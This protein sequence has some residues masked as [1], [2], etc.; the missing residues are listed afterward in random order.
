MK[1]NQELIKL[2]SKHVAQTY[3]RYPIGLV[4]GKG[5]AVWDASGKK[6]IDIDNITLLKKLYV[7]IFDFNTNENNDYVLNFQ[8]IYKTLLLYACTKKK[9]QCIKFLFNLYFTFDDISKIALRQTF[10]YGK[11]LLKKPKEL[12]K[13]YDKYV[14]EKI[15]VKSR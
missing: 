7:Q 2:T 10:F 3:G 4:R 14:L 9:K 5:T 15:R 1:S 8:Y 13:W 12:I 11:Y 6:Y